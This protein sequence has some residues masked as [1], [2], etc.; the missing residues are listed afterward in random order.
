MQNSSKVNSPAFAIAL[1]LVVCVLAS[2]TLM[3]A[4][5]TYGTIAGVVVDSSGAAIAGAKVEALNQGTGATRSVLT[6]A[7]GR[8]EFLSQDAW[9]IHH[10]R[11]GPQLHHRKEHQ[12]RPAGQRQSTERCIARASRSCRQECYCSRQAAAR[13]PYP[14]GVQRLRLLSSHL[15]GVRFSAPKPDC[16]SPV[17]RPAISARGFLSVDSGC[18]AVPARGARRRV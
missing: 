12:C 10:Y 16:M 1:V 18:P 9:H 6:G 13:V 3:F 11:F 8:Y 17:C 15:Q 5:S 14:T 7:D 2:C 4:Q